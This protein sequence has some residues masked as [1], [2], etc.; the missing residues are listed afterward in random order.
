MH[1]IIAL[2]QRIEARRTASLERQVPPFAL[3]RI[4]P[5]RFQAVEKAPDKCREARPS[6]PVARREAARLQPISERTGVVEKVALRVRRAGKLRLFRMW[7][8]F[9]KHRDEAEESVAAVVRPLAERLAWLRGTRR[10]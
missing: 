3:T 9:G 2:S 5:L 10:L 8:M 1:E 6:R 4:V 7:K